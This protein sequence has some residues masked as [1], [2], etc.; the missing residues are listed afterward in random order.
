MKNKNKN[1][2]YRAIPVLKK[3]EEY[4]ETKGY[5]STTPNGKPST[6]ADYPKRILKTAECEG[7]TVEEVVTQIDTL[8]IEYDVGGTKEKQGNQSHNAVK[9]ALKRFKEFIA[10]IDD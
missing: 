10:Q 1:E 4:L 9:N 5:S 3:F 7:L 8:V 6:T 2:G